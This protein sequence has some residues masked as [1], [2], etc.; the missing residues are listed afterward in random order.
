[1]KKIM[2]SGISKVLLFLL[3]LYFL[4]FLGVYFSFLGIA[5]KDHGIYLISKVNSF[6]YVYDSCTR[7]IFYEVTRF[8]FEG[9][10]RISVYPYLIAA[11]VCFLILMCVAA[12]RPNT[13]EIIPGLTNYI[14]TDVMLVLEACAGI[15]FGVFLY[16]DC[17]NYVSVLETFY[18]GSAFYILLSLIFSIDLAGRIKS[19][20]FFKN[21]AVVYVFRLLF[22]II[23][24]IIEFIRKIPLIWH[25]VV[26]VL[27]VII[28][29][30]FFFVAD[31]QEMYVVL[32]AL[33]RLLLIPLIFYAAFNYKTLMKTS[34]NMAKGNLESGVDTRHMLWD[35]KVMG[36]NLNEMMT[37]M[38]VAI[39]ERTKSERMKT[40]LITNVSHDIKTPLTSII[41]YSDLI[42][43]ECDSNEMSKER[44]SEYSDVVHRQSDKLKR[45][46]ED[47]I[48]VSKASSGNIET[49]L[50]KC[51]ADILLNQAV[52]EYEDKLK[53]K[54]IT[55]I[56]KLPEESLSIM[57]DRQ[58]LWRVFDNLLSNICKYSMPGTRAYFSVTEENNDVVISFKNTSKEIL[59]VN[60]EELTERF[61]RADESRNSS[62][63]GHG[64]GLAIAKN[65][66]E[67]QGGSLTLL[68]DADLLTAELRF[69]KI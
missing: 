4:L 23:K 63:E 21:T 65:L 54:E 19:R 18:I 8:V 33:E 45:L 60:P 15:A 31:S 47:L 67:L 24:K 29:E 43:T 56:M 39:S 66:T 27:A 37:G 9:V 50:E 49:N 1:M 48:E 7:S 2:R 14:P 6:D 38:N 55:P 68:T 53:E 32:W 57:A 20:T 17:W 25:T 52:G 59:N 64:L 41:N 36:R 3:C 12:K 42:K 34:E 26:I 58:H 11:L 30:M 44:V 10:S 22:F 51:E 61:V 35:F 13:E 40:E 16:E 69:T 28:M 62:V 5:G 46:L